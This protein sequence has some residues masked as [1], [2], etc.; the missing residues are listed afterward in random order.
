MRIN[1]QSTGKLKVEPDSKPNQ[2]LRAICLEILNH[3]RAFTCSRATADCSHGESLTNQHSLLAAKSFRSKMKTESK[4][5]LRCKLWK[6]EFMDNSF[7]FMDNSFDHNV[8]SKCY[9]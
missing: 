6:T 2:Q 8:G 3:S 4:T 1:W 5:H 9:D 7:E